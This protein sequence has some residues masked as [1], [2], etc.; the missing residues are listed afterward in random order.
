MNRPTV[1][2]VPLFKPEPQRVGLALFFMVFAAFAA[3]GLFPLPEEPARVQF[4]DLTLTAT[5]FIIAMKVLVSRNRFFHF[6]VIAWCGLAHWYV[7][8][9]IKEMEMALMEPAYGEQYLTYAA[10][11]V[12]VILVTPW[13]WR[14]FS[15]WRLS[16]KPLPP[17]LFRDG[18]RY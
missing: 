14:L 1:K 8:K 7:G 13:V 10:P 2:H 11:V 3:N 6:S 18:I 16:D 15:E 5:S 17:L 4:W 9:R 12:A